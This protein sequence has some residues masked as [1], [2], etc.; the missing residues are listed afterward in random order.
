MT[1]TTP[2]PPLR[3]PFLTIQQAEERNP[4]ARSRLRRWIFLADNGEPG[5]EGLRAAIARVGRSVLIDEAAL[6]AWLGTLIGHPKSAARNP[7]GR[8]GNP[9]TKVAKKPQR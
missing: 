6:V 5:F 1:E 8:A 9:K 2:G 4:G 7:H 3:G